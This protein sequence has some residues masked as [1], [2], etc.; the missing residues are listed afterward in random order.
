MRRQGSIIIDAVGSFL[1]DDGWAI[2][3][4][5]ALS[6]LTSLFPFL[7]FVTALA[8]VFDQDYL[9]QVATRLIFGIWPEAVAKPIA[10]QVNEVLN[11]P[12]GGLLTFGAVLALYFS[13]SAI[14][15]LRTGLNR[16]YDVPET[17]RWYW[18]RLQSILFMTVASFALLAL[19]FLVVGG[20]SLWRALV[21][22]VPELEPMRG[23][24]RAGRLVVTAMALVVALI[25]AHRWLPAA[26][27]N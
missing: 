25:L 3:S 2:A 18:L 21:A 13:S 27:L 11:T 4:H 6:G 19:A 15:A 7:I 1:A 14:E 20:P 5:I 9:T 17:R 10:E 26:R 23:Y 24:V 8:G 12:R 16:A 22:F